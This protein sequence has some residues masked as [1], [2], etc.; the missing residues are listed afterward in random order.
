MMEMKKDKPLRVLQ[1]LGG[2][3][4][5]GGVEKMLLN[6]YSRID[7]TKVQFDFCFYRENTFRTVYDEFPDVLKDSQIFELKAFT[8]ESNL[9]GYI[10]SFQKVKRLIKENGY[11]VVHVNAGRPP[12]LIFGLIAAKLAGAKIRI[13]HSH[14]TKGKDGRGRGTRKEGRWRDYQESCLRDGNN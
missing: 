8:K 7:R 4:A 5:I 10:G 11:Q 1:L 3:K 13:V 14:S 9:G 2:D 12:L 6:Y